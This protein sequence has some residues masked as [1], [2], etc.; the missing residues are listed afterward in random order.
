MTINKIMKLIGE[1]VIK[2][3]TIVIVI[4]RI[5]V[6]RVNSIRIIRITEII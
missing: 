6:T 2:I 1:I 5:I 3:K 4:K